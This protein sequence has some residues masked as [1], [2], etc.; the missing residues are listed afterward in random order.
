MDKW[1]VIYYISSSGNNPVSDF[2]DTLESVTQ[3]KLLR[4]LHNITEY[5]LQS[6][7][8]HIKKLPG[9]PF[10]EIR[11]LGKDNVRIIYV[12]PFQ[13]Q[14]LVLHGFVKKSQKTPLKELETA[15]KRYREFLIPGK[16]G[17]T[18]YI[19]KDIIKT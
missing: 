15:S 6:V 14:I 1:K 7:I 18:G 13:L 8:P 9:T 3:S 10:W 5:G 12:I 19:L 11:V 17:L 2:L 16:G 4:I